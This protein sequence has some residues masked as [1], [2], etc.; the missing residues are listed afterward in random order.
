LVNKKNESLVN[1]SIDKALIFDY[2]IIKKGD[3]QHMKKS[4]I[5]KFPKEKP[6]NVY[7]IKT[8]TLKGKQLTRYLIEMD[9]MPKQ[10]VYNKTTR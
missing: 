9:E 5:D 6:K 2:T 8:N 4:W 3:R 1:I 7:S 10:T